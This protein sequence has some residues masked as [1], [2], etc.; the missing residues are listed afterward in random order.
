LRSL[1]TFSVGLIPEERLMD[2]K[3]KG[4][5]EQTGIDNIVKARSSR[6][7]FLK[8]AIVG[9]VAVT[10]TAAVAKKTGDI[11]LKEDAQQAYLNDVLPGDKVLAGRQY[12]EMTVEEK[13]SMVARFES[14]YKNP[15][16]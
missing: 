1:K 14:N 15:E 9:T 4:S 2:K 13:K 3:E 8:K 5:R 7:G 10:A 6:R 16:A 11:L 12:V